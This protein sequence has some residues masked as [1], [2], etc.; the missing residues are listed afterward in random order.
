MSAVE[1]VLCTICQCIFWVLASWLSFR[2]ESCLAEGEVLAEKGLPI[3]GQEKGAA[4]V[5]EVSEVTFCGRRAEY[6][7]VV[8]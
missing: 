6:K 2:L 8:E 4:L 5:H 3:S 1:D 7:S